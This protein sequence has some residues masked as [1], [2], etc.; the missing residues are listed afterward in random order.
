MHRTHN[1]IQDRRH[2]NSAVAPKNCGGKKRCFVRGTRSYVRASCREYTLAQG[3][4]R[5]LCE[6]D[7]LSPSAGEDQF[8]PYCCS[9]C[10]PPSNLD[11]QTLALAS[12]RSSQ[13]SLAWI[14]PIASPLHICM[15]ECMWSCQAK[16][17]SISLR[18]GTDTIRPHPAISGS[19]RLFCTGSIRGM[20]RS[21]RK[22]TERLWRRFANNFRRME[23]S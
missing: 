7:K 15:T 4:H 10:L 19:I 17:I 1:V 20:R 9:D 2:G 6:S 13:R 22:R 8:V 18:L 14:L 11:C 12:G 5:Y 21:R 16:D 23:T 3:S